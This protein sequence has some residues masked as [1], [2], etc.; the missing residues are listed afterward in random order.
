MSKG[1]YDDRDVYNRGLYGI[2]LPISFVYGLAFSVIRPC[3]G[4]FSSEKT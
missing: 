3:T 1:S 2:V 4:I